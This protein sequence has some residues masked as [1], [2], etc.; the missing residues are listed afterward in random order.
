MF[1]IF[2]SKPPDLLQRKAGFG[3]AARDRK[4]RIG[5]ADIETR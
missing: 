5:P 3:R 2:V 1:E 4:A